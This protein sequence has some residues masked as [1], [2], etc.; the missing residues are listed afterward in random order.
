LFWDRQTAFRLLLE[1]SGETPSAELERVALE[2]PYPDS[3]ARALWLLH[4]SNALGEDILLQAFNDSEAGVRKQAVELSADRIDE[5]KAIHSAVLTSIQD[6][7]MHVRLYSA[8]TLGDMPGEEATK[9][10]AYLAT[11]D[12]EDMWMRT[13][14]LS[15]VGSRMEAFLTAMDEEDPSQPGY[16]L[17]MKDLG[18]M[19]GNGASI[20]QCRELSRI[21]LAN[22]NPDVPGIG[23]VLGL[24]KGVAGRPELRNQKEVLSYLA[25]TANPADRKAF[26]ESVYQYVRDPSASLMRRIDAVSLLGYTQDPESLPALRALLSPDQL[27]EL[28]KAAIGAISTQGNRSGGEILVSKDVWSGFTPQVKSTVIT[29]LVSNPTFVPLL[30]QAIGDGVV[31]ASDIPS[32]TRQ[33]LMSSGNAEIKQLA[34]LAFAE[35]EGGDRMKTYE[36]YKALLTDSGDPENGKVVYKKACGV[37]HSYDNEGGDV[38]PDLTGIKNQPADAIL[39]HIVVPNYEVYPTYQTMAVETNDGRHVAGWTVSETENSITLRTASGTDETI[40]RSAIKSLNNTG[41]S[42]MPDGLEQAMSEDEMDDLIAYLKQ[43]S[44]FQN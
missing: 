36:K 35:L 37:C 38:G 1:R 26:W 42:L 39:L 17:I 44:S 12:G 33:R 11:R 29:S 21:T 18:E 2:S 28:Q 7:D 4:L 25:S 22:H 3:R 41:L 43:G 14:I 9:A 13:A 20:A 30:L 31:S 34:E 40:L 23:T 16:P 24:A 10:L 8:L 19:F 6:P 15:G 5:S 32:I 27:P